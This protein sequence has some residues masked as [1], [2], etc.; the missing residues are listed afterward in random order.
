MAGQPR[1]VVYPPDEDGGRRVRVAGTLL[2]RAFSLRDVVALLR[3]AGLR[4]WEER[5][6]VRTDRVQWRGGGPGEWG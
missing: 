1:V 3:E 2:G 4:G 6:V 5:D